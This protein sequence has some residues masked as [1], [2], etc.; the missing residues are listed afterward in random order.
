MNDPWRNNPRHPGYRP[1]PN[2]SAHEDEEDTPEA[3]GNP[4]M[5]PEPSGRVPV[6]VMGL[7]SVVLGFV[8]LILGPIAL[9]MS[10]TGRREIREGR[11]RRDGLMTAG[12]VLGIVG[13]CFGAFMALYLVFMFAFFTTMMPN[14]ENI[15][16]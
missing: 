6:F 11:A 12:F 3:Y 10:R 14:F 5:L 1:E 7:L 9:I 2:S 13:T 16:Y 8:G 4:P 15:E